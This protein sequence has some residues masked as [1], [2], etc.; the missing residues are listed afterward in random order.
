M[1]ACLTVLFAGLVLLDHFLS[2][3]PDGDLIKQSTSP[4]GKYVVKAYLVN[5]GATVDFAVRG[6]LTRADGKVLNRKL[7]W[8]YHEDIAEIKW[9]DNETVSINDVVLNVHTDH[10]D[11]RD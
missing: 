7:Y 1:L 4:N 3:L 10:Y 9:L 11:F 5:G 8:N 2:Q 6:E